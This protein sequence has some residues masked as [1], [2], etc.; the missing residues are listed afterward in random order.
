MRKT[1]TEKAALSGFWGFIYGQGFFLFD[2]GLTK[3]QVGAISRWYIDNMSGGD[4]RKGEI[5]SFIE[6]VAHAHALTL[7]FCSLKRKEWTSQS[8]R[9]LNEKNLLTRSLK[10]LTSVEPTLDPES[11]EEAFSQ[12][13]R[14]TAEASP[15]HRKGVNILKEAITDLEFSMFRRADNIRDSCEPLIWGKDVGP[16]Q[17]GV[18][19]SRLGRQLKRDNYN[20]MPIEDDDWLW[21]LHAVSIS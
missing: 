9:K 13:S 8:Q 2:H 5:L 19:I 15:L 12:E 1:F 20:F 17:E 6:S 3:R 18:D 16:H 14:E 10:Y 11:E 21:D 4:G 7:V